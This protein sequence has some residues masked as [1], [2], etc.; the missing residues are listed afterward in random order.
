MLGNSIRGPQLVLQDEPPKKLIFFFGLG[1]PVLVPFKIS[2]CPPEIVLY[3][4][5][6]LSIPC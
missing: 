3:T 5:T 1:F 6:L 4:P 2:K